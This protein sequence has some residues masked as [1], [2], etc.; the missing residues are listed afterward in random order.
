MK[1]LIPCILALVAVLAVTALYWD[2]GTLWRNQ[3]DDS[4]ISMRYAA[5]L[6][7]GRGLTFNEGEKT[8]AASS[9][10]YTVALAAVYKCGYHDLETASF[11]FNLLALMCI[12][13]CV[14][15]CALRLS[16]NRWA[17]VMLGIIAPLHGFI[18]G[19]AVLGMDT[20]PFA[21]LL[22]ALV[23]AVLYG[24]NTLAL[25]L[26]CAVV[27]MRI[28]GALIVPMWWITTGGKWRYAVIV[29]TFISFYYLARFVYYGSIIPD[30]LTFKGLC[31]YYHAQPWAVLDTWATYA[32]AAPIFALIGMFYDRRVWWIGAYIAVSAASCLM[33]VHSD[34]ERYTAHLWPL[35]LIAGSPALRRV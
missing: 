14:Y 16:R 35:M 30:S 23:Y 17:S 31:V 1:R 6:A 29:C 27:L 2:T 4:A 5:N 15:L 25:V 24:R 26:M 12:A 33:G 10:L 7:E 8:D 32:I 28:E 34:Y 9:S 11:L 20:V 21:A 13:A 18:S 22:C 3:Y 19:W